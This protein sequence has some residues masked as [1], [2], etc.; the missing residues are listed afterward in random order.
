M[1]AVLV[2]YNAELLACV[3]SCSTDIISKCSSSDLLVAW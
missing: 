1:L 2:V 3:E